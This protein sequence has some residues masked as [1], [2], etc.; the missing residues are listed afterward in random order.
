MKISRDISFWKGHLQFPQI[1]PKFPKFFLWF[2]QEM[3][4]N[5]LQL[6]MAAVVW[7]MQHS[8]MLQKPMKHE[9]MPISGVFFL[10]ST[11]HPQ[12]TWLEL[13]RWVGL[14]VWWQLTWRCHT[15][16]RIHRRGSCNGPHWLQDHRVSKRTSHT[17]YENRSSPSASH[18]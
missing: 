14:E 13:C 4:L 2:L 16:H 17:C 5:P 10:P 8:W 6:E 3:E 1:S 11:T 7:L 12:Q 9:F 15:M 18:Y